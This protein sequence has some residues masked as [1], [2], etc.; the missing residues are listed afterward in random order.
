MKSI[1]EII[2]PI[3]LLRW[4]R[5]DTA[6]TG[7]G[8]FMNVIAYL[9][10]ETQ[11]TDHPECVCLAVRAI[12]I[13]LND[14]MPDDQRHRL[15]LFI[16]R[17][18][19]TANASKEVL[20]MRA[21]AAAKFAVICSALAATAATA[22][23]K[24]TAATVAKAIESAEYAAEADQYAKFTAESYNAADAAQ[25]AASAAEYAARGAHSAA[26][27][28]K[29]AEYAARLVKIIEAA[30]ACLDEMCPKSAMITN[31]ET[32]ARAENFVK[33]TKECFEAR[34]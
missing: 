18:M 30:I 1:T 12:A 3:T 27:S 28:A 2:K 16:E 23:A 25:Y 5:L 19:D 29:S 4:S 14:L 9:N 26:K 34:L 8:C 33:L 10:G 22:A 7:Q 15:I 21:N 24:S 20:V 13:V 11:I 31:H 32:F 17:V 6:Q